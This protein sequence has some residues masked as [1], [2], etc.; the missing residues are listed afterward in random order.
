[1]GVARVRKARVRRWIE[2]LERAGMQVA[3]FERGS[4]AYEDALRSV[5]G[6]YTDRELEE[7]FPLLDSDDKT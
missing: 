7:M 2:H 1:M 4:P 6:N 5:I 3:G